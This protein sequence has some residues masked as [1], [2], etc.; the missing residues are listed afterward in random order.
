MALNCNFDWRGFRSTPPIR[1]RSIQSTR[2][3]ICLGPAPSVLPQHATCEI[4]RR[5]L[6]NRQ[7]PIRSA[8]SSAQ[9]P[10][11][12]L[13]PK[14]SS[15]HCHCRER[16]PA[17]SRLLAT[18]GTDASTLGNRSLQHELIIP[19]RDF[20]VAMRATRV[21]SEQPVLALGFAQA[22]VDANLTR[23]LTGALQVA[24]LNNPRA[25]LPRNLQ[26]RR[27]NGAASP[28]LVL[29]R[30]AGGGEQ[31]PDGVEAWQ[32]WLATHAPVYRLLGCSDDPIVVALCLHADGRVSAAMRQDGEWGPMQALHLPG[33]GMTRVDLS[34]QPSSPPITMEADDLRS[35]RYSR[36]SG[37]LGVGVLERMQ[38]AT[39]GLIGVGRT[40]SVLAHTLSRSGA[41]VLMLDPDKIE[42]HNLD[43]DVLPLHEGLA[44]TDAVARFV[45]PLLRPGTFAD[46]RVL[47]IGAPVC[48]TLLS[49]CDVLISCVDDDRARLWAA[50][51]GAALVKPHLDIGVS[52]APNG[53][54]ADLRLTFPGTAP[55]SACLACMGGFANPGRLP[56]AAENDL[57]EVHEDFRAQRAGSLRTWSVAA[58][59]M[60]L[61]LV[62]RLYAGKLTSSTFRHLEEDGGGILSVRDAP[63]SG[64][65][66]QC[67]LCHG[68]GGV[69][70]RGVTR[71]AVYSVAQALRQ[72]A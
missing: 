15:P 66:G 62:E 36:Q 9:P 16:A 18:P 60:G 33:P 50:A 56:T 42:A 17:R 14:S 5:Y 7:T 28:A 30:F 59:H 48:G 26:P 53:C 71:N 64:I 47:D 45:R 70:R 51:W 6:P 22:E 46:P 57:R 39:F 67:P 72:R 3:F 31:L 54:G 63:A 4:A 29:L 61:R 24:P 25:P 35:G 27:M 19:R 49:R 37:A 55:G 43:G 32:R 1:I 38:R 8:K 10:H 13:P 2:N 20:D 21:H 34:A 58:A 44:K 12:H 68:L 41:S 52:A 65:S 40:G 23:W 69:G 11:L